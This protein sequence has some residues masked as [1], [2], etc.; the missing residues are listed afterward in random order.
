MT[1]PLERLMPGV[2]APAA[3]LGLAG[4]LP[5][6]AGA[7][8]HWVMPGDVVRFLTIGY[9]VAILSFMGGC[10]WGFAAAG[11]GQGIQVGPLV[12]SVLPCLYGW[13]IAITP[14]GLPFFGLALGF[15]GLFVADVHLTK[16]GGAPPWW[17][18][19]RLPLSVGAAGSLVVAGLA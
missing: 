15:V 5:F 17:P 14:G 2:P 6:F 10:R 8:A 3:W 1:D 7:I 16:E 18:A 13:A 19:L 9:G 12:L 4:L 11:L